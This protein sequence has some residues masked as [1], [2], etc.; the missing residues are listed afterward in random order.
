ME[1]REIFENLSPLDH[2]YWKANAAL[3]D[4]LSARL[5]EAA[6]LRSH[7]R[8]EAALLKTHLELRG[9]A[10]EALH[11]SIDAVVDALEPEEVYA[12]EEST[13][14]NIRALV[15]VLQRKLPGELRS[16]VHL[17][18]TS[19]DILD[20][21][22]SL[23]LRSAVRDVLLPLLGRL[24]IR[25]CT[26]CVDES[27]TPQVGR[28]HGQHAVP[29]TFG[30]AMAEY[31]SR[32][33]SSILR[34]ENLAGDLRGKLSGAVGAYNALSLLYP[35]PEEVERTFLARLGLEPSGHSTQLVEPEP[36][37]R[38][39]LELNVA[40]GIV[41]NLADDLRNLQR[42]EIG[43]LRE[44]FGA[45]QVGSSTMPQK[46]NPWNSEHVK[47]LWKTFSPR[48]MTFFMD[49][50]SEH[51]RDLTNSAS[52]RFVPE[53]VAGLCAA[54]NRMLGVLDGLVVDRARMA[55]NLRMTGGSILAE[56]AYILLAESGRPDAHEM[57]RRITLHAEREGLS[58]HESLA[59]DAEA[60]GAVRARLESLG[61]RDP[62][63]FFS[64]PER[65]RGRAA[66]KA[67]ALGTKYL[68]L[69]EKYAASGAAAGAATGT[70]EGG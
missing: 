43:E 17:G 27:E 64:A 41:A 35:D 7:A 62:E 68:G 4:A 38:L 56:P 25:I 21:S 18:A 69:M 2:R 15:N 61:I 32:L 1:T 49:Q 63:A 46:R 36:V 60:M 19:V 51:Q 14:H 40:F 30:F 16:L 67:R 53:F 9:M 42:T 13:R 44:S 33:G 10:T 28:T 54:A 11:R 70:A 45:G 22:R 55:A 20:T 8:V 59:L 12:E 23:T 29:L 39:L 58:L 26:L 31:A 65:Y 34:V 24:E 6:Q 66:E 3:F 37:L 5:S 47:S 57:L 50:I 52:E 48:T